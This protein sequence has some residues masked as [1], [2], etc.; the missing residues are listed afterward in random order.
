MK[1][2]L[3]LGAG[4]S[5][6]LGM[7]LVRELTEVFLSIFNDERAR[8]LAIVLS[9]QRPYTRDRP[10]NGKAITAGLRR[11]LDYRKAKGSNYEEFLAGLQALSG[12]V[13][14]TQSDRDSYH[15]LFVFFYGVI[16]KI[17]CHYQ[18]ASYEMV[19]QKNKQWFSKLDDL[20]FPTK[21]PG[22]SHS[23][24]ICTLNT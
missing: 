19:Y 24:T 18:R 21:K 8:E 15:F 14:P 12:I 3:L 10:I 2:A 9:S 1:K 23:I 17:L 5:Y 16:H 6:D 4:F 13:S 7:P 20:Y 22:F 11:L